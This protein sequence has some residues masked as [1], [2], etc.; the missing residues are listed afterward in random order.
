MVRN[1]EIIAVVEDKGCWTLNMEDIANS[2]NARTHVA[3][4][5][6]QLYHYMRLNH[7][8]HGIL[9]SYDHTWFAYRSQECS[10]CD[11]PQGH[12][13]L[14]ISEGVSFA[15]K[16]PTVLQCFSF[17]NS[18]ADDTFIASPPISPRSSRANSATLDS[19]N[20]SPTFSSSRSASR[21]GSPLSSTSE[22]NQQAQHF[23]VDDFKLNAVLGQG[24]SKVYLDS[25]ESRPIALKTAD[26]A[27][28][29]EMLAE[30][31]NE[32]AVYDDLSPLQGKGIPK[33]VC[34]GYLE[35]VLYC[36]GVSVCGSVPEVITE[37]QKQ[38]LLETLDIIHENGILHNDIKKEN[39]LVDE[40]GHPFIID[41]GFSTRSASKVDQEGERLMLMRLIESL[42]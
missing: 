36:V 27:K 6:N 15:A 10:V 19:R 30:L 34:H 31:L 32:V 24:R 41:F 35:D 7:R 37:K 29:K 5:V 25:Y 28:H 33:L 13:T 1:G 26:I 18:I 8:K 11:A 14:Y 17:F 21:R 12:E 3:S 38:V 2:Y 42:C 20:P 4:A 9:T 23:D 16:T 22:I 40:G 39:I